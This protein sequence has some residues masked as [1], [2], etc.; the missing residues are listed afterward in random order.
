M[1]EA[2]ELAETDDFFKE[3]VGKDYRGNMSSTII[4]TTYGRTIMLQHDATS[5]SPHNMI[6]GVYGTKGAVLYD[7]QPPR[8]STGNHKWVSEEEYEKL[9]EKYDPWIKKVRSQVD[10]NIHAVRIN[11][12][13]TL[14]F[15][16]F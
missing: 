16:K 4:K 5:P 9:K 7:P 8:F 2:K 11:A 12:S 10:I 14:K 3:F 6:H 13:H 1:H 15:F